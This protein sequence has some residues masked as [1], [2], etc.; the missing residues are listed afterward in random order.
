MLLLGCSWLDCLYWLWDFLLFFLLYNL[1]FSFINFI[2]VAICLFYFFFIFFIDIFFRVRVISTCRL[3][4][5]R[6]SFCS[7]SG[8]WGMLIFI[9]FMISYRGFSMCS[10]WIMCFWVMSFVSRMLVLLMARFRSNYFI[11]FTFVLLF[12]FCLFSLFNIFALLSWTWFNFGNYRLNVFLLLLF[13]FFLFLFFLLLLLLFLFRLSLLLLLLC[14]FLFLLFLLLLFLL[15]LFL[16]F[17]LLFYYIIYIITCFWFSF[18]AFNILISCWRVLHSCWIFFI[19]L[20]GF[21]Y[22]FWIGRLSGRSLPSCSSWW[23]CRIGFNSRF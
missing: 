10:F 23:V 13:L 14:F 20:R 22:C 2:L 7:C 9:V 18:S 8:C 19:N 17:F 21:W 16:F 15:L 5:S 1:C 6:F 11:L 12:W 3:F 4:Y